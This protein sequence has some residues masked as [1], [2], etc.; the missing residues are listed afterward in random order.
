MYM[1]SSLLE[2]G[3]GA[4]PGISPREYDVQASQLQ[5]ML[6]VVVVEAPLNFL[7][8]PAKLETYRDFLLKEM[9]WMAADFGVERQLQCLLGS[10][11]T[12]PTC[13]V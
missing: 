9:A 2:E 10:N 13:F 1:R 6:D 5:H 7:E 12:R 8:A 11:L 4:T 3:C